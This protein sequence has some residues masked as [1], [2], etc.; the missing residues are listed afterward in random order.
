M[1]KPYQGHR[2]YNAWNV[3]LYLFNDYGLYQRMREIV[4]SSRTL[5]AAA[6]RLAD[7]LSGQKTPDGVPFTRTNIRLALQHWEG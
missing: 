4:R 3:S 7:E 1:A 2:S 6:D 5:D